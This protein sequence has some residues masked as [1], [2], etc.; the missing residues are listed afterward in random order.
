MP[1]PRTWLWGRGEGERGLGEGPATG[2][3][4][5][6]LIPAPPCAASAAQTTLGSGTLCDLSREANILS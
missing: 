1:P 6:I 3:Y 5:E 2:L 4:S